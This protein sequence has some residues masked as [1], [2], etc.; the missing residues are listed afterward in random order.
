MV[1][2]EAATN[3][4]M[5]PKL[6]L[7]IAIALPGVGQVIN[8]APVRGLIFIF[9]MILLGIITFNL[10]TPEHSLIGRYSGGIFVYAISIMDAYKWALYRRKMLQS[11]E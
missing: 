2:R 11:S 8:R 5:N 9:Y 6:V 1:Q 10:T 4:T 7:L 3:K